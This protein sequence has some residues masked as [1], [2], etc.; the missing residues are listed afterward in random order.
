MKSKLSITGCWT[1]RIDEIGLAQFIKMNI[2]DRK[3][4]IEFLLTLDKSEHSTNDRYILDR[5]GPAAVTKQFFE[6]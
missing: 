4:Y 6:L 1:W 2:Q 5:Y 3:E